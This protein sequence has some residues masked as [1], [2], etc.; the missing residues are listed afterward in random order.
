MKTRT[1]SYPIGFRR[2]RAEWQSDIGKLIDWAKE[3]ELEVIDIGGDKALETGKAVQ[4]AGL[5]IGSVDLVA[6]R[7]MITKDADKRAAA[8]ETNSKHIETCAALGNMNYFLVMLPEDPTAG[9]SENFALMME[10]YIE[11]VPVLKA[12]NA[13]IV[14]E[15]WPGPG[16]LCCTPE[17]CREFFREIPS[18]VMGINYDPSHLIRQDIDHIH[19]LNE[20]VARVYHVHGKDT[21]MQVDEYYEFGREQPATFAQTLPYSGH[22]WRY[23]IPGHGIARWNDIFT[24]LKENEYSGFV[25]IELEDRNFYGNP[26]IEQMG[27]VKG[28]QFLTG[29]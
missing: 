21:E 3:N 17:G 20:F 13:R 11:L 4:D 29:C 23:T 10:A 7:N 22:T 24:I 18:P 6:S 16:A 15:G 9:R 27:I 14:I 5:N 28:A 1:G 8:I 25:S 26:E 19:F 12:N 2:G